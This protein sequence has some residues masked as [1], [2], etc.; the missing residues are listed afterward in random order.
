MLDKMPSSKELLRDVLQPHTSLSLD[1]MGLIKSFD[2]SDPTYRFEI[3]SVI[4]FLSGVDKTL[5][6]AF[7]LLYL[8]GEVG[9]KW[10]SP[11]PRSKPPAGFI[12]CQ[13][14][15]TAKIVKLKDLGVDITY[16][17]W[18]INLRNEYVHSCSVYAGYTVG[19]EEN[20][21]KICLEA[22]RP[23]LCFPLTPMTAIRPERIQSYADQMIDLIGSFIDNTEWQQGWATITQKLTSL[24]KNPEPEYTQILNEPENEFEILDTLN[25]KF[26]GDGARLLLRH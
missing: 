21:D 24:P 6:L 7:E 23:T 9:W 22:S 13:R 18:I 11:N 26:I 14:G 4:I 3:A 12:E 25:E 19:L 2:T 5:S 16:L 15:L 1:L 8:A 17:Q 10:M 20:T